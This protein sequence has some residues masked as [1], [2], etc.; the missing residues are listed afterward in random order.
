[1]RSERCILTSEVI[2]L[3]TEQLRFRRQKNKNYMYKHGF[4]DVTCKNGVVWQLILFVIDLW[5]E[6]SNQERPRHVG[7]GLALLYVSGNNWFLGWYCQLGC[8][9]HTPASVQLKVRLELLAQTVLWMHAIKLSHE[10]TCQI[11]LLFNRQISRAC[12]RACFKD[13]SISWEP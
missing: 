8:L 3:F 4:S 9:I 5:V 13:T 6:F 11:T 7:V 10:N 1:M 2:Q 12:L